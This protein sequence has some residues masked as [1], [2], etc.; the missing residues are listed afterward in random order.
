M[1]CLQMLTFVMNK[2][3]AGWCA[4]RSRASSMEQAT[5]VSPACR[6]GA[7]CLHLA[8]DPL[9]PTSHVRWAALRVLASGGPLRGGEAQ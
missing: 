6:C 2:L 4:R 1:P 8:G 9:W 7:A 5:S 3:M